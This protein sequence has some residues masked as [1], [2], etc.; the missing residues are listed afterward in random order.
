MLMAP[1]LNEMVPVPVNIHRVHSTTKDMGL[2]QSKI[3]HF[4]ETMSD[5]VYSRGNAR[6]NIPSANE[7]T[8]SALPAFFM[9]SHIFN[10]PPPQFSNRPIR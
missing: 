7:K 8:G 1:A 9:D 10:V 2:I 4:G 5:A 6:L 3:R